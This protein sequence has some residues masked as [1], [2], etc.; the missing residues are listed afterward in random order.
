MK[1]Y[2]L[3]LIS[4]FPLLFFAGCEKELDDAIESTKPGELPGN[5]ESGG[6]VPEGYFAVTFSPGNETRVGVSGSDA[7]V[8][9]L[10]YLV[11]NATTGVFVKEKV[12][13]TPASGVP[14]WPLPAVRDTLPKGNYTAVFLGNVEKTLFPY[15]AAGGGNGYSDV[16]T[17]YQ[18]QITDARINL[19]SGQMSDASEYY[20]AKVSFSDE[21]SN[22]T[23]LLQRIIGLFK[24]HRNFV[25]AQTALN[26][27]T[28]HVIANVNSG[29]IIENQVNAT[30]PGL[31]RNAFN[32]PV[33]TIA[34][35]TVGGLDS[36]TNKV[37]RALIAPVTNALYNV[38]LQN[39]VNQLG[40]ALTGNANHQGAIDG[41]GVLLNPWNNSTAHTAVLKIRDF[42]K[43]IDFDHIVRDTYVGD[44]HFQYDFTPGSIYA[45]KDVML[46]GFNGLFNVRE[47]RVTSQTLVGGLLVDNI[48]DSPFLLNGV[49][50]NIMDPVQQTIGSNLRYKSDYSFV[51]LNYQAGTA[52][53]PLSISVTLG[54][55]ASIDNILANVPLVGPLLSTTLNLALAPLRNIV[56]TVPLNVPLL[57]A[58]KLTLSG[59]WAV[60]TTY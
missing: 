8:Q 34:L 17:N 35:A 38:L 59:S 50:T 41:L 31:V 52:T 5:E 39:I 14:T 33:L 1:T 47:I 28:A 22:P 11:Y 46:R 30:L 56:I 58:D 9:H 25:D 7:R 44:H 49:F 6:V 24:L 51:D 43:A 42:P 53:A 57:G 10:R 60:P 55:I 36:A 4:L 18:G 27:L 29:N 15:S 40:G 16:L 21:T 48:L 37:T 19:P 2:F 12:V 3:V 32:N 23:I 20:W 45:E 26:S 54:N 13:L